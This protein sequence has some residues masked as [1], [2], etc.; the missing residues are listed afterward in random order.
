MTKHF[1]KSGWMI[2]FREKE[3]RTW[4]HNRKSKIKELAIE[5][6]L[7]NTIVLFSLRK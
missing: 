1:E 3:R 4:I 6:K 7:K 5:Y 2:K